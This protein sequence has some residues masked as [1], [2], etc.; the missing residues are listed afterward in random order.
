MK[1]GVVCRPV[2]DIN[3][4]PFP[5]YCVVSIPPKSV[6]RPVD[7]DGHAECI[8]SSDDKK[9]LFDCPLFLTERVPQA[10]PNT[11]T[12]KECATGGLGMFA[13]R[14]ITYGELLFAERPLLM[15]PSLHESYFLAV[16][17]YT[18]E[19]LLKLTSIE[20]EQLLEQALKR[21]DDDK[22]DAYMALAN[23]IQ[24]DG[25]L[26]SIQQTNA[27]GLDL[28]ELT[29]DGGVAPDPDE[30]SRA[31]A[32]GVGLEPNMYSVTAKNASRMNHR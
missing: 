21:M 16:D 8:I 2:T 7:P 11:I 18:L 9:R 14:D 10:R 25:P 27:F 30:L 22:K 1:P 19:D 4:T 28:N 31:F 6:D 5:T 17:G 32:A 20:E 12:I 13:T 23:S 26:S 15:N 29:R 24:E 3:N